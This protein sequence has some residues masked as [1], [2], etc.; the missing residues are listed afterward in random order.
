MGQCLPPEQMILYHRIDEILYHRWDPI[1]ISGST[2]ARDE[3]YGYLPMV[4]RLAL[5]NQNPQPIARYLTTIT[6]EQMGLHASPENDCAIAKHILD[7]KK[8]CLG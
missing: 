8:E 3:Y 2:G 6:T 1:G 5:E 4:F 7:V